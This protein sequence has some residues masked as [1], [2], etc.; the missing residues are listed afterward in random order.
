DAGGEHSVA[1]QTGFGGNVFEFAFAEIPVENV[2]GRELSAGEIGSVCEEDVGEAVVIVVDEGHA[3]AEGLEHVLGRGG[4][5]FVAKGEAGFGGEVD[6]L[7]VLI[8]GGAG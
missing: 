2:A 7:D 6:E 4:S 3:G 1:G 5:V 8:G